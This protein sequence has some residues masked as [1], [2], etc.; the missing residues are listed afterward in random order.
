LESLSV[1]AGGAKPLLGGESQ[2]LADQ[3][4]IDS[5]AGPRECGKLLSAALDKR[6]Q[7]LEPRILT[8]ALDRGDG[9][10]R[11]LRPLRQGSLRQTGGSPGSPEEPCCRWPRASLDHGSIIAQITTSLSRVDAGHL[12][13]RLLVS[14]GG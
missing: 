1:L 10:L 11:H 14:S 5:F 13:R 9:R 2:L 12:A 7:R 3:R 6:Q 4:P 8:A